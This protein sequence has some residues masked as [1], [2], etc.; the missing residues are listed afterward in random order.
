MADV[1]NPLPSARAS[2][3]DWHA[4]VQFLPLFWPKDRG[5]RARL[6]GG[7]ISTAAAP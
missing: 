7:I 6:I 4:L 2:M 1:P 3:G 5:T